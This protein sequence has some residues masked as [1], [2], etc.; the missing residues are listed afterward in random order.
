MRLILSC[1]I[2]FLSLSLFAN[3]PDPVKEFRQSSLHSYW[4]NLEK[5]EN[6]KLI[7]PYKIQALI[8]LSYYPE[9]E[10]VQIEFKKKNIKTTMS[11]IPKND[12]FL[13]KKK[14]RIYHINVDTTTHNNKG[15]LLEDVPL[16]AQIG[17]I[18]HEL[19]HVVDYESKSAVGILLTGLSYLIPPFRK[20]LEQKVDEITIAHGLGYQ[21]KEFSDYVLN[22]AD[23]NEKY[24][25]YKRKYYYKPTQLTQLI[26]AYPIY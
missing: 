23:V 4:Q 20:K 9:L 5:H 18:A 8:A 14:N 15:L 12:F 2:S 11:S 24:R 26:L 19:G 3:Q 6:H 22:Q 7:A 16:N 25:E 10:D 17:V 13:R 1:L 21:V